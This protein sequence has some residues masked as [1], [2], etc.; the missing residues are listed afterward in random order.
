MGVGHNG[1]QQDQIEA[2]RKAIIDVS[3]NGNVSQKQVLASL[4]YLRGE[5]DVAILARH[6]YLGSEIIKHPTRQP[7]Y[8][9]QIL[10]HDSTRI[11][12]RVVDEFRMD[13]LVNGTE[14][15]GIAY[16]LA[17]IERLEA[18]IHSIVVNGLIDKPVT[19]EQ[20]DESRTMA[21]IQANPDGGDSAEDRA[22]EERTL[23]D[24]DQN[25]IFPGTSSRA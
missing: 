18:N 14:D 16:M 17:Y 24:N 3:E 7:R 19:R 1:Y 15:A 10:K 4:Y 25:P 13:V 22:E 9:I 11:L 2:A 12:Q 21:R 23:P 6:R 20:A 5:I 8:H